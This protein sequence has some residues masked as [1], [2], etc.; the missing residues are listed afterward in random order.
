[1]GKSTL[2]EAIAASWGFN[3]EGGTIHFNFSTR[4]SHSSLHEYLR[5]IRGAVKPRDGFFFRAE[6]YYN[7]ATHIEELDR[8]G[9]L[10]NPVIDSYGGV[11]LHEQSHGESFFSVFN[12]RFGGDG[13]YIL[14]EPESALSPLRQLSMLARIHELVQHRSQLIIATHSP[15]VM[16]YPGADILQLSE[17]GIRRTSLEETEHYRLMKHFF[18]NREGMLW[19]LLHSGS[20]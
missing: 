16:A 14:D 18:D 10:G 3:P 8:D 17:G 20:E 6:S 15:I 4:S 13:F 11:S 9:G 7:V 1:M 5:I 19:H 2:L 12:H